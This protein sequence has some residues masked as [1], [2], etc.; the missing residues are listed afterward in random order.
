MKFEKYKHKKDVEIIVQNVQI[1]EGRLSE[2]YNHFLDCNFESC[3]TTDTR[4]MGVL[5]MRI[6]WADKDEPDKKYYQ[7]MHL[8]YSEYGIDDY[9]EFD[10]TQ[11]S[12]HIEDNAEAMIF[13]WE[14]FLMAM[15]AGIRTIPAAVMLKLIDEA[16]AIAERSGGREYDDDENVQFRKYALMRLE[17]MREALRCADSRE[18]TGEYTDDEIMQLVCPR[19]L[20]TCETI[21]YFIMRLAELDFH[22]AAYLSTMSED[23][24]SRLALTDQGMQTLI[25]NKIR[26]SEDEADVA[27][28]GKSHPYRFSATTL[29]YSNYFYTTGVIYLDGDY[30]QKD[31]KVTEFQIGTIS[32]LSD[33]EAAVQ[34]EQTEYITVFDC[35]DRLLSNFDGEKLSYLK[36]VRPTLVNNGW[37][38]TVYNKDNSHANRS[39]YRISDDVFGYAL[40]TI[41]GEFILMSNKYMNITH[42][43]GETIT[44]IY[45]PFLKL[46]GRYRLQDSIFQLLCDTSGIMFRQLIESMD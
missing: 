34:L 13:H 12:E 4:L 10:C 21:N 36:G 39:D 25:R 27:A 33:Y 22:A 31:C 11:Y 5:A 16:A 19:K 44:S 14:S 9:F 45:S 46:E 1:V 3:E 35:R 30:K 2:Y 18:Y 8:D 38:Y 41:D 15:G 24:L 42:M 32:K 17:L 40:L 43:D 7:L 6:T 23:E 37:L 28:D 20:S 26:P 29:G